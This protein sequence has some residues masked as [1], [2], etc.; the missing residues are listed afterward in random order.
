MNLSKKHLEHVIRAAG[1]IAADN[2]V[3][4]IGSNAFLGFIGD[5]LSHFNVSNEID[6]AFFDDPD[7]RKSNEVDGAIGEFSAFHQEFKYFAHGVS[8]ETATLPA[9]WRERLKVVESDGIKGFCLSVEDLAISKLAAGRDKDFEFVQALFRLKFTS[10]EKVA[11][12]VERLDKKKDIVETN[13][14]IC[15]ARF[16]HNSGQNTGM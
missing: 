5:E 10:P 7:G 3:L 8:V 13:L 1:R 11:M 2:E 9:G 14:K 12:L 4:I 15:A 6:I 16:N